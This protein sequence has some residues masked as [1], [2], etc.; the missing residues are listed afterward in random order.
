MKLTGFERN[1]GRWGFRNHTLVLPLSLTAC[2]A[3]ERLAS[4]VPNTVAVRHDWSRSGALIDIQRV[5]RTFIGFA[6]HPN[7]GATLAIGLDDE[8]ERVIEAVRATGARV[9]FDSLSAHGGTAKLVESAE[10]V[11]AGLVRETER[12]ARKPAP[13]AS[14][15]L[16]LE[17]GGSDGLSGVTANP[18][19]GVAS[20]LLVSAGGTSVLAETSELVGAEYLLAARAVSDAVGAD[21]VAMIER[22]ERYAA[23]VGVDIR[24]GQPGPGNMDGGLSTIEEKSLGAAKKGGSAPVQSVLDFAEA[25]SSPGLHV[26]DTPGNDIE[27]MVGMVAAGCQ[28]VGFTTGRGTP[29]GSPIAPCL[30][31]ATNNEVFRR[32]GHDIDLNSGVIIDGAGVAEV[33]R[34]IFD[35]IIGTAAGELTASERHGHREFALS[36]LE[37][38]SAGVR[39]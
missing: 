38:Q 23:S 15:C 35:A 20:D 28:I 8:D 2:V 39:A 12:L 34:E 16:G 7:V 37:P 9:E 22:F 13:V 29:T 3:A 32:L 33:G 31:I 25:P 30:K 6:A 24:G 36:R 18:A 5:E 1:D 21:V 11:L 19:L 17:C 27:Q 26:M 4:L 14:I 10:P